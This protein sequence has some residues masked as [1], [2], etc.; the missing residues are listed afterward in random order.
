MRVI[1]T[2][3]GTGS[4]TGQEPQQ[5][6]SVKVVIEVYVGVQQL[7][8]KPAQ[9]QPVKDEILKRLRQLC[10]SDQ[11]CANLPPAQRRCMSTMHTISNALELE[12]NHV[13]HTQHGLQ[14]VMRRQPPAEEAALCV[15]ARSGEKAC[16]MHPSTCACTA[17]LEGAITLARMVK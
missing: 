12:G 17:S 10:V 9:V 6:Y 4:R 1:I 3:A 13:C 14:I 8:P 11:Y 2:R 15:T 5:L 16:C 7:R